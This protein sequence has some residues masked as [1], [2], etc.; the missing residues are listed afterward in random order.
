MPIVAGAGEIQCTAG[1]VVSKQCGTGW[2]YGTRRLVGH[3]HLIMR[4]LTSAAL[5]RLWILLATVKGWGPI[6]NC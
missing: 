1:N 3:L 5:R 6:S 4:D 2:E